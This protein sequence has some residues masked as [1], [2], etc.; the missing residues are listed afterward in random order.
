MLSNTGVLQNTEAEI[1]HKELAS[2]SLSGH[3]FYMAIPLHVLA[4][5]AKHCT[6]YDKL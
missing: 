2:P 3:G 5:T 6:H 4:H 1:C